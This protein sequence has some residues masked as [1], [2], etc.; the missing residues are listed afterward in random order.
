MILVLVDK[1]DIG[2]TD[3]VLRILQ[4]KGIEHFRIQPTDFPKSLGAK[5]TYSS[6]SP[7][8]TLRFAEKFLDIEAVQSV[9]DRSSLSPGIS[10][11][12]K[13]EDR[14]MARNEATHFLRSV[15]QILQNRFWVNRYPDSSIASLKPYQLQVAQSVG[16]EI[17]RTLMTNEPAE[18]ME[19]YKACGG[20]II[21]KTF[22]HFTR[23]VE[24]GKYLGIYTNRVQYEDLT[25]RLDSIRVAPCIFQEY[26]AKHVELRITVVGKNIFAAEIYSQDSERS[27]DDWRR[28]DLQNVAHRACDLPTTLQT[29]I[30]QMMQALNL[31][32]GSIDMILTPDGRYVFLEVNPSGQWGWIE[33]LTGMPIAR[34]I[35]AMLMQATSDYV[36]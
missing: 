24:G 35:A 33:E 18:V 9:W 14:Q 29:K 31:V 5:I 1:E 25:A 27:R 7:G 22:D 26:V 2:A 21:Y 34:S 32:Y 17:P 10:D 11:S 8:I 13:S 36:G 15:R 3:P 16:L 19:F 23:E 20:Q 6:G 12:I 30:L 4:R 28:Y